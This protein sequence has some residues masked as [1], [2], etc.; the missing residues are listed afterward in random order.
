[1]FVRSE[2]RL[3][4]Y[5]DEKS[6]RSVVSALQVL[7]F[8]SYTTL[9]LVVCMS[10]CVYISSEQSCLRDGQSPVPWFAVSGEGT[11]DT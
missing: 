5:S 4:Q 3:V 10:V 11:V 8:A 1:M 7:L 2:D 6:S 9:S